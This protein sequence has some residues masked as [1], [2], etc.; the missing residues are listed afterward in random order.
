MPSRMLV[1]GTLE[2]CPSLYIQGHFFQI[3]LWGHEANVNEL[4]AHGL[5]SFVVELLVW[6]QF[7]GV[8][9]ERKIGARR[10]AQAGQ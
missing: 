9:T 4:A 1:G 5:D 2:T 3:N 10:D 7:M 6:V 8:R